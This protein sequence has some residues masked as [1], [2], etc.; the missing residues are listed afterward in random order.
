MSRARRIVKCT[1]GTLANKW[2]IIYRPIEVNPDFCDIIKACCVLHNYVRKND[3]IQFDGTCMN[4]PW[5][6]Y[7]L[8]ERE[9]ALGALLYENT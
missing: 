8:L 4:V 9:A 1:F 5:N 3:G 7:G 2:K 6:V